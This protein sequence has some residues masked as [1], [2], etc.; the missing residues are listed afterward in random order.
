MQLTRYTRRTGTGLFE[1]M[2]IFALESYA[3]IFIPYN[4]TETCQGNNA[5]MKLF[6]ER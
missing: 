3:R 4:N 6:S 2:C 5:L 1:T